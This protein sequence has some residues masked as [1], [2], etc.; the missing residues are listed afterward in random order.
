MT[1]AWQE[2]AREAYAAM[3]ARTARVMIVVSGAATAVII[4]TAVP[5]ARVVVLGAPGH[6]SPTLL[7]RGLIAFAPGLLAYAL[8]ALLSRALYA[9][10]NARTPATASIVGWLV[11]TGAD[12][13]LCFV[14]PRAWI[15]A[16]I[17]IGT[18]VGVTVTAVWLVVSVLRSSGA[19]SLAGA[20]RSLVAAVLGGGLASV[21]GWLLANHYRPNGVIANLGLAVIVGALAVVVHTAVSAAVDRSTVTAVLS[22][23]RPHRV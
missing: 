10:G 14:M 12:V 1:S 11:A 7:S 6:A 4:A 13:M 17:G 5:L 3:L 2:G 16:A 21:G 22:R 9:Q 19:E 23:V 15:V 18:S 8:F 20:R